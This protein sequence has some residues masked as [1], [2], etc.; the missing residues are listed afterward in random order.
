[1]LYAEAKALKMQNLQLSPKPVQIREAQTAL[2]T[3]QDNLSAAFNG[4]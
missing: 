3:L 2:N 1:M 4:P